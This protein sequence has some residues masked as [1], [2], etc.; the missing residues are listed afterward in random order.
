MAV[1][2]G[3]NGTVTIGTNQI[4]ILRWTLDIEAEVSKYGSGGWKKAVAG[5]IDVKGSFEAVDSA[6]IPDAGTEVS[7]TL[8]Q[9]TGGKTYSGSAIVKKVSVTVVPDTGEIIKYSVD[10]EGSDEWTIT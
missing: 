7:L 2:S 9:G 3:K 10:F 8:T 6:N 4:E 5:V 1:L